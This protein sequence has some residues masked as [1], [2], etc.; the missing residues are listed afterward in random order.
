MEE[1]LQKRLLQSA[2]FTLVWEAL[3]VGY[4][5]HYRSPDAMACVNQWLKSD[6]NNVRALGTSRD[7]IRDGKRVGQR[8][9]DYRKVLAIDPSRFETRWQLVGCLLDLGV[10]DEAAE[11]LERIARETPDDTEV[12]ARL[13]RCY[14][15]L[16]HREDGRRLLEDALRKQPENGLCL[17][18]LGQ[19]ELAEGRRSQAEEVLHRAVAA[20][21]D[22]YQSH[23][24]LFQASQQQGKTQ[25][26]KIQFKHEKVKERN[27]QFS[28][29]T[30]RRLPE[31]HSTPGCIIEMG[32]L[33]MRS[34]R[35]ELAV[36]WL[37][38]ALRLD[39]GHKPSHLALADF[40][41]R[42]GEK[43]LAEF[44]RQ[45]SQTPEPK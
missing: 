1:Y 39:P 40:Y 26:A 18:T 43:N 5:R 30:S 21:P 35:T 3:A 37:Q 17:R 24:L 45:Q 28:E 23:W 20:L 4:L 27:E 16:R 9:E 42:T 6:P 11:H 41:E 36:Q 38:S 10:Y 2:N 31:I 34:G 8:A 14:I 13:A 32:M 19:F 44:H 22:D 7:H 29:L 15:M 12:L 25:E 33:F